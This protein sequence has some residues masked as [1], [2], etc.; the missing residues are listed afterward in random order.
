MKFSE[1]LKHFNG[2]KNFKE[3]EGM[4]TFD[5]LKSRIRK[6][7]GDDYLHNLNYYISNFEEQVNNKRERKRKKREI[8]GRK[9]IEWNINY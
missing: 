8:I 7:E 1:C 5:S 4:N 3:L 2:S 9:N 6:K